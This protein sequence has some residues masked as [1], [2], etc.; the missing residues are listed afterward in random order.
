MSPRHTEV[1]SFTVRLMRKVVVAVIGIVTILVGIAGLF[2]PILPGMLLIVAGLAI[3]GTEYALARRSL[4]ALRTRF[5][6]LVERF[7]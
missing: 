6:D 3:L 2:L 4:D 5:R 7:R 1:T